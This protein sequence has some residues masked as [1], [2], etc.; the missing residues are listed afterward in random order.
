ME[1]DSYENV[2]ETFTGT[3]TYDNIYQ[4]K[5]EITTTFLGHDG[6]EVG[7]YGGM[8]PYNSRPHYMIIRNTNVAGRTTNDDKL[9]VEIEL[10]QGN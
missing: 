7:I 2:F 10:I 4:L 6:S 9:N 3:V 5:E 1:V 8:L